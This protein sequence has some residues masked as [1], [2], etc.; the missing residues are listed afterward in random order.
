M[1]RLA[2]ALGSAVDYYRRF[3]GAEKELS[4]VADFGA[5]KARRDRAHTDRSGAA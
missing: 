5:A 1:G 2:T 3:N 4:R